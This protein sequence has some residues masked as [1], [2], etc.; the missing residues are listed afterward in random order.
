M[1][2]I[3]ADSLDDRFFRPAAWRPAPGVKR[4][5]SAVRRRGDEA[6]R[7]FGRRWDGVAPRALRVEEERLRTAGERVD[8]ALLAALR[9]AQAR[10]A[11]FSDRQLAALAGFTLEAG[12]GLRL[13]QRCE[14][15]ASVGVYVPGGR[16]P[17]PSS[18]LMGVVPA[19]VAGVGRIAVC[20]PP[21]ADGEIHPALLAAAFV[22][23]ADEVYRVGGAQAVA[24]LAIGTESIPA[25]DKIVGPGNR[26]VTQAKRE[27]FGSVGIDMLAGPSEVFIIADHTANPAWVAADLLAQAE[28]DPCATA[29]LITPDL[30]LADSVRREL[31]R[32][33]AKL[34]TA[35][36]ARLSLRRNGR[37]IITRDLAQAV[38]VANRRAPEHL[39]LQLDDAVRWAPRCRAFGS[40]FV[41]HDA[42]EAFADYNAGINHVLP[43]A[44]AARFSGGLGARDFVRLLTELHLAPPAPARLVPAAACLAER[45]GL[46]AHARSLRI[47][48]PTPAHGAENQGD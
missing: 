25:V 8:P 3:S 41:G 47:R 10:I 9:G 45:E 5:L 32:Q 43:T 36:V 13:V 46:D 6:L 35:A 19:R 15:L 29:V 20:T 23:G 27:V 1:K 2:T 38:E 18:L 31:R 48:L 28:H 26:Y 37:I 40:L 12:P 14:P 11:A 21:A 16:Y 7:D 42:A 17:L 34:A 30:P 39:H 44:G 33:V 24:A 22:A 4:I